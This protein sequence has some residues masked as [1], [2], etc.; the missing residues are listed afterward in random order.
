[1]ANRNGATTVNNSTLAK[2]EQFVTTWGETLDQAW[3]M[4]NA[5]M[6]AVSD[7][8]QMDVVFARY[9]DERNGVRFDLWFAP[10][11]LVPAI[12]FGLK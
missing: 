5:M 4:A 1:M 3:G 10:A 8:E 11:N 6:D 12:N 7:G 9:N 2:G